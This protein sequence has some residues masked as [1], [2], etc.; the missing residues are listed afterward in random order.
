[1]LLTLLLLLSKSEIPNAQKHAERNMPG[2]NNDCY[3]H[4]LIHNLKRNYNLIFQKF[5]QQIETLTLVH[6]GR[7]WKNKCM[8][9]V[10]KISGNYSAPQ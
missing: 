1:M 4:E 9:S 3:S 6:T 2:K 10:G 7:K 8:F 5:Q